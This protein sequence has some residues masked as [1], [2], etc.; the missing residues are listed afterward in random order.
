MENHVW[1]KYKPH[2]W[3]EYLVSCLPDDVISWYRDVNYV[4]WKYTTYQ[5]TK[6]FYVCREVAENWGRGDGQRNFEV[7]TGGWANLPFRIFKEWYEH[8]ET[9]SDTNFFEVGGYRICKEPISVD[10]RGFVLNGKGYELHKQDYQPYPTFLSF[11]LDLEEYYKRKG[12]KV[13]DK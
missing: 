10:S 5:D 4:E 2:I 11:S 6:H 8:D 12:E 3:I 13:C 1:E 7:Y 9:D